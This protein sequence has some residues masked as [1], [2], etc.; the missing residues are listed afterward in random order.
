MQQQET[1]T[2]SV[3]KPPVFT[4]SKIDNDSCSQPIRAALQTNSHFVNSYFHNEHCKHTITSKMTKAFYLQAKIH[5]HVIVIFITGTYFWWPEK[6]ERVLLS[7]EAQEGCGKTPSADMLHR[8]DSYHQSTP[9]LD[10]SQTFLVSV[11]AIE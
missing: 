6:A 5:S 10:Q 1:A 9:H 3:N 4:V 7:A 11:K 8:G 2:E